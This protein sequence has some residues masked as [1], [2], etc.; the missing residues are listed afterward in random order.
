M[1]VTDNRLG[2]FCKKSPPSEEEKREGRQDIYLFLN[3][4]INYYFC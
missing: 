4:W 3:E 1:K 2:F